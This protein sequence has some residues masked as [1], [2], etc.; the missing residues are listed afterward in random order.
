VVFG[1]SEA[2]SGS[3]DCSNMNLGNGKAMH[4]RLCIFWDITHGE[5]SISS[6]HSCIMHREP[7]VGSKVDTTLPSHQRLPET[8]KPHWHQP[9]RS[10]PITWAPPD[11]YL[12]YIF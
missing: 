7:V 8:P 5:R 3:V 1:Q 12:R 2:Q 11:I 6:E 9:P 10:L 4:G